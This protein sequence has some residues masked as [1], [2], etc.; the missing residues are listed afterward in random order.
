MR[1]RR[2][3]LRPKRLLTRAIADVRSILSGPTIQVRC[4]E[5][6]PIGRGA[7]AGAGRPRLDR[8]LA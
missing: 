1:W 6:P 7:P 4:L 5:C 8:A 3:R 2:C